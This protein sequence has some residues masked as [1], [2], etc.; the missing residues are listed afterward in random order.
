M[1]LFE[2]SL[3]RTTDKPTSHMAAA[4]VKVSMLEQVFLASLM[5][6]GEA[7]ANE[8]AA[9]ACEGGNLHHE[10]IRKRAKGLVDKRL[11][12]ESGSRFCARTGKMATVYEV[13][14][15]HLRF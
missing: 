12:R 13:Q 3:A 10:S 4:E 9:H 5:A 14:N 15:G 6:L 8:V 1:D 7:T 2:W 11:I